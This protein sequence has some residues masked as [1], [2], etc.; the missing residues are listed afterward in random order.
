VDFPKMQ[1]GG[2]R[3]AAFIAYVPQG[4]RDAEGHAAAAARAEAMLRH[5]R[6]R[7]DGETRHFCA[8]PAELEAV[9]A[10]EGLAVISAVENG[11]AMGRDLTAPARWK[12]LGACYLTLTHNGHNEI[13]DS[14]IPRPDLGDAVAEHGGLSD[15]GRQAVAVLN[16]VGLMLDVSHVA[17]SAMLQAAALSRSPLVATHACC[18]ALCDHPRN[19]DDEQ[20]DMLKEVGGLIQITAMT[21]FLR[22]PEPGMRPHAS[23]AD[24]AEH[25]DYA[26]RRIGLEHVGVSSDFDG[27][28]GVTGWQNAAETAGVTEALRARGYDE[29]ALRLLWSGNF[30]RVWKRAEEVAAG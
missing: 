12:A 14:A 4:K 5:I 27:G 19:L 13:A 8:G 28:G 29:A 22:K 15:F 3:A 30:V 17:K 11:Y 16:R 23:V 9:F 10:G 20:L 1:Q 2:L 6:A 7:A 18:R 21:T 24:M 26:V 25:V